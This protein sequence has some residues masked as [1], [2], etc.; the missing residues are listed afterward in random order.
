MVRRKFKNKA[1][2][3]DFQSEDMNKKNKSSQMN[4]LQHQSKEKPIEEC[5]NIV[6]ESEEKSLEELIKMLC[7]EKKTKLSI[8]MFNELPS[9]VKKDVLTDLVQSLPSESISP[10]FCRLSEEVLKSLLLFASSFLS[11]CQ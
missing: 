9:D 6:R 8:N 3:T 7:I 10:I 11:V 1:V 2:H 4:S 5:E